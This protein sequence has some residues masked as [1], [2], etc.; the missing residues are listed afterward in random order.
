MKKVL[1]L[2]FAIVLSSCT[3]NK[4]AYIDVEVVMKEYEA[5]K[6]LESEMTAKQDE[7]AGE[8]QTLQTSFQQKVQEYY[9][10]AESMSTQKR[11][12]AEQV[13]QQEQQMIQGR[14]QQ[15]TQILQQE[16]QQ[17]SAVLIKKID[18]VVAV[19]S[20]SKGFNLVLG[21]SGNG[22]VMYGDDAMNI[23]SDIVTLLNEDYSAE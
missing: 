8:L 17:K 18:S 15:A 21:T 16:N 22:T 9:S 6:V 12:E 14:Q 19:F 5:M 7:M 23:S 3:Q 1:I 20:K 10:T 13:L 11:A 4:I 2:V